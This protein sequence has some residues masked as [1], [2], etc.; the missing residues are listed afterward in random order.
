[1][2]VQLHGAL[3][4]EISPDEV[5]E[6]ANYLAADQD[7]QIWFYEQAP[8]PDKKTS[9]GFWNAEEGKLTRGKRWGVAWDQTLTV[10]KRS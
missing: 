6:W 8:L 5:P 1:M 9:I 2:V 3:A 7:G 4:E 10:I